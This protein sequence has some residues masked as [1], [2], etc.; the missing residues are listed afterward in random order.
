M[1]IEAARILDL[2]AVKH[3]K[4]VFVPECKDGPTQNGSGHLRLD[5]W[6]MKRSWLRMK[7]WGYEIK[8]RRSDF[9][10]DEKWQAYLD[11]CNEFSFVCPSGLID[12]SEVPDYVGLIWVSKTGNRLYT[13]RKA[14]WR[15]IEVPESLLLY[16]LMARSEIRRSEFMQA[17]KENRAER[18]REWL[19]RTK[20]YKQLGYSVSE[21]VTN[22]IHEAESDVRRANVE[23]EA[24]KKTR[25]I[26]VDLGFPED[27]AMNTW[28]VR[29]FFD[30]FSAGGISTNIQRKAARVSVEVASLMKE[31][32]KETA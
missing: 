28:A 9:L 32:E 12:P 20:E 23:V 26:L 7:F 27:E 16:I 21:R 25:E 15:D 17:T 1:N 31:I 4:D 19:Q 24:F 3:S 2:L 11:L 14:V 8:V 5:A 13:K 29:R 6:A 10:R 30:E 18:W 22:L